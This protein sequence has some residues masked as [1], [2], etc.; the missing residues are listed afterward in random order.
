MRAA[1]NSPRCD[2]LCIVLVG[3][4]L[5][6][7][8]QGQRPFI[9]FEARFAL[10]AK[11]MWRHGPSW[12]PTT[13]GGEPYPD[14]PATA[15]WFIWLLAHL[16]HGVTRL[17]AVLPTALAATLNLLLTYRIVVR[18][19]RDWAFAAVCFEV[20]AFGF[21]AEARALSLDQM[22]TT[23]TLAVF[24]L[25]QANE[26]RLTLRTWFGLVALL[27]LGLALR[28]PLGVV[29]PA[30][31]GCVTYAVARQW[32]KLVGFGVTA[33]CVLIG[34][35]GLMLF[36]ARLQ[37]GEAFVREVLHM[38]VAGRL[39][40][41]EHPP[42]WYYFTSSFGNEA[43]TYPL[44]LLAIGAVL[45]GKPH[46]AA[47]VQTAQRRRLL[48]QMMAWMAVIFCGL[49]I[50]MDK[51]PRYI[52]AAMPAMAV[53]AGYL[54][55]DE[56]RSRRDRLAIGVRRCLDGLWQTLPLLFAV[57]LLWIAR[58][59]AMPEGVAWWPSVAV[60]AMAQVAVLAA[61]RTL[62]SEWQAK[63]RLLI[64][65]GLLWGLRVTLVEPVAFHNHDAR[66][67]VSALEK[68]RHRQP[69]EL[70]FYNIGKDA[71]AIKYAANIDEDLH[72]RFID[73]PAT[74]ATITPPAY[75]VAM[76]TSL[77]ELMAIQGMAQRRPVLDMR[78]DGEDCIVFYWPSKP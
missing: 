62:P 73:Q 30:G 17:T 27:L 76:K 5:F 54:Y 60:L 63:S 19:S 14:Y 4:C 66:E 49:S 53:L 18:H 39:S 69:G 3:L 52:L 6:L 45:F 16:T 33:L 68:L 47:D 59:H 77:P 51:K 50:P 67:F 31:V 43:P 1:N 28:G 26:D 75:L 29:I 32:R 64:A 7:I 12:F 36:L 46:S 24:L 9:E 57:A 70:V 11:E 2:A 78:F 40:A 42:V 61:R 15:T 65:A 21:L 58:R 37:G 13:Y 44:A 55:S 20:M 38:E 35:F 74:L 25:A 72:A 34:G 71:E 41:T 22:I 48:L 23:V 56:F 8:G 10:F